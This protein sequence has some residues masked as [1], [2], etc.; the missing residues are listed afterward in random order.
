MITSRPL[1]VPCEEAAADVKDKRN[2]EV[3]QNQGG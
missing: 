2:A 3:L 1:F